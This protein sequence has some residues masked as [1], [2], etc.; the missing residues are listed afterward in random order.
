MLGQPH[1]VKN[2]T[3]RT[4]PAL[5]QGKPSLAAAVDSSGPLATKESPTGFARTGVK[6][7]YF[8]AQPKTMDDVN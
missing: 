6:N 4:K 5:K 2:A 8:S 1:S 7:E 3:L